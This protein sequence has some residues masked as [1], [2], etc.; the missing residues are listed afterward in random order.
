MI[1]RRVMGIQ[2]KRRVKVNADQI[3]QDLAVKM[4][5]NKRQIKRNVFWRERILSQ[6]EKEENQR[7]RE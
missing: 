3:Q 5:E 1:E 4:E 6:R 7:E 2:A